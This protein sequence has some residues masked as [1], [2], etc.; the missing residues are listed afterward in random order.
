M[1]L[2]NQTLEI[3]AQRLEQR[4]GNPIYQKAWKAA[5]K[6]LRQLK[7]EESKPVN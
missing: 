1:T 3:A 2:D 7:T 5:A 6:I 4:A